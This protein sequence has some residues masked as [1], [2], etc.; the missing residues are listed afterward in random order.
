MDTFIAPVELKFAGDATTGE[1]EGYGAVFGN[2][3]S[4]GDVIVPGA[5]KTTLAEH[6][7]RGTMPTMYVQHG[8]ALGGDPLPSGVWKD[9]QEDDKGLRVIGK[10]S[11]LDTDHGRRI[12]SLMQDGALNGLSIGFRV[13]PGGATYGRNTSEPRRTLKAL[14]L[15]EVSLVNRAS[16]HLARV[17][18]IKSALAS[19][20]LPTIREF[21]D[22]LREKGFSRSQSAQIAERGFKSLPR[23]EDGGQATTTPAFRAAMDE[24]R[25]ASAGFPSSQ[26]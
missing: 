5:F 16:N 25:A 21:E 1:F 7:T 14:H 23:D 15:P 17:D 2:R 20:E 3:D 6:K 24:F 13:A 12:R 4:H 10:L 26:N 19:G 18:S 8:P 11:A 22:F 9:M